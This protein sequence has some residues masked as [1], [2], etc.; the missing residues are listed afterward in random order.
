MNDIDRYQRFSF[1][2]ISIRLF[3][4]SILGRVIASYHK[5]SDGK[6]LVIVNVYVPC[7]YPGDGEK[8]EKKIKFLENLKAH[9]SKLIE[10]NNDVVLAGDL[11]V[12]TRII[13]SAEAFENR[14]NSK[15]IAEWHS[16]PDKIIFNS[17]LNDHLVD[18]LR[19][20]YPNKPECYTCWNSGLNG[21]INN[22]GTRI[23]YILLSKSSK[24][25][26]KSCS[27]MS[28]IT[29]SDHCPFSTDIDF[30]VLPSP[31]VPPECTIFYPE[32]RGK[33][34]SLSS[35]F[36]K[37]KAEM[38]I[39]KKCTQLVSH[40]GKKQK[41]NSVLGATQKQCTQTKLMFSAKCSKIQ[42][43]Q[44][45]PYH[46][47]KASSPQNTAISSSAVSVKSLL[48]GLPKPPVCSGH[49]LKSSLKTV[50]KEG[51]NFGKRFYCC[52]L[53]IGPSSSKSSRCTF[54]QWLDK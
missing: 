3:T 5:K 45:L 11:N 40:P 19:Y 20:L 12:K 52:S 39:E 1:Q 35:M 50:T 2:A 23:D 9:V 18:C 10:E 13:D 21:R 4:H 15:F 8:Y 27:I 49:Q 22:Y 44:A 17:F 24:T 6:I 43:P 29:G 26:I 47:R 46:N 25:L 51:P 16:S 38:M 32:L 28:D 42:K 36:V 48:K 41:T 30:S 31:T 14:H 34:T 37:R 7:A 53:P 33:Q 54:F